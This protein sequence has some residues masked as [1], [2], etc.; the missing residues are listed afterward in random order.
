M[1]LRLALSVFVALCTAALGC[2]RAA[3]KAAGP[4]GVDVTA[5]EMA[6]SALV[7]SNITIVMARDAQS[8]NLIATRQPG[9][10]HLEID[11]SDD[12]HIQVTVIYEDEVERIWNNLSALFPSSEDTV[13]EAT[14]D[15]NVV[16]MGVTAVSFE[17]SADGF[18]RSYIINR[19]EMACFLIEIEKLLE[20]CGI[21][22]PFEAVVF[23]PA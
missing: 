6:F 21:A 5:C 18:R 2:D 4:A 3:K 12:L 22:V 20:R 15:P 8:H 23:E 10:L 17:V 7:E 1:M 13:S 14:Y 19:Q 9:V 16:V 11:A